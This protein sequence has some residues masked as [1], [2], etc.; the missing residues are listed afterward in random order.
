MICEARV[1]CSLHSVGPRPCSQVGAE[2]GRDFKVYSPLSQLL[3]RSYEVEKAAVTSPEF[4][5]LGDNLALLNMD[6]MR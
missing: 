4:T 1:L 5:K 6:S 3:C 2:S